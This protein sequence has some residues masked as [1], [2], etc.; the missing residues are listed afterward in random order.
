MANQTITCNKVEKESNEISL[1]LFCLFA[2]AC[3][4][5]ACCMFLL[6]EL[7]NKWGMNV[8]GG[9]TNSLVQV[10]FPKKEI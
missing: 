6:N 4:I 3:I 7:H 8:V 1:K 10:C 5:Y 2:S 9:T